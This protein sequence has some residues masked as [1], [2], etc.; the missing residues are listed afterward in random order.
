MPSTSQLSQYK[1]AEMNDRVPVFKMATVDGQKPYADGDRAQATVI[2]REF[3][4]YAAACNCQVFFFEVQ[5]SMVDLIRTSI[6]LNNFSTSRVRVIQNAVS[7]LPSHSQLTFSLSGG[8]TTIS[9]GT[10]RAST[11]RL[12][13]VE[14]PPQSSILMLKIDVEGFEL[15]ALRSAEK[16]FHEKRIH[17]LIFEYTAW[18]TD[19][20]PQKDLI[21]FVEKTLGA[22]Q[23]F[24]LDRTGNSVYGPLT[25]DTLNQFHEDHVKRHL[26]T[27]IYATFIESNK[28]STLKVQPYTLV[29]S[30][31]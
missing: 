14:W 24:A 27:D 29:S 15:N 2:N 18:W 1:V 7:D 20:A 10:L 19:R 30:F 23:L 3:G 4:L 9:N 17:H 12:D 5:P 22:K 16:L 21:P 26:Q 11:I 13:D 25:R 6:S 8:T 31:A 28:K